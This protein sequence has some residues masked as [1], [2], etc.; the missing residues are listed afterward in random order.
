MTVETS[1]NDMLRLAAAIVTSADGR[2]LTVRKR[3]TGFLL[4]P[5]GKIEP[6]ETSEHAV[7]REVHEELGVI[8]LGVRFVAS[9]SAPAANEPGVS[10]SADVY[11]VDVG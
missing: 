1:G 9:L 2:F 7:R 5:G 10:V 6:G 8:A 3:N 11:V 4:Q